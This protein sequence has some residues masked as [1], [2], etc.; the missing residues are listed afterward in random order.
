[1][2]ILLVGFAS[3]YYFS[4]Q[5][6]Q[7]INL[8][9]QAVKRFPDNSNYHFALAAVLDRFGTETADPERLRNRRKLLPQ[10]AG[11]PP[12]QKQHG[13]QALLRNHADSRPRLSGGDSC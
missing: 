11:T 4:G 5:Q 10:V 6:A 2:L 9:G 7:A 13:R 3:A 8:L 12:A 1:M